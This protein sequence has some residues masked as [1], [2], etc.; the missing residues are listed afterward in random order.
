[1]KKLAIILLLSLAFSLPVRT[2]A[3]SA[4]WVSLQSDA[5]SLNAPG[6]KVNLSLNAMLN[7]AINGASLILHYD[8]VCFKIAGHKPGSL[9]PGTTSFIQEQPGQLD[10][11]YY[12]QGKGRGL[13][14]EGSLINIQLEALQ[15]CAS[16]VS[17]DSKTLT[18]GV[19][20]DK[21]LAF[22]LPG[23]E[24]RSMI[25]HLVPANGLAVFNPPSKAI[26]PSNSPELPLT[27]TALGSNLIWWIVAIVTI[28]ILVLII[29]VGLFLL[30]TDASSSRKKRPVSRNRI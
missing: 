12:F 24:Y 20:D 22:N 27:S 18:L 19:L 21:G 3:Q 7:S 11:T 16:D 29:I 23:V 9:L 4:N 8:P 25:V 1:M 14:G 5:T 2:R 13:T 28:L 10:L 30:L 26:L 17:V 6:Q 15:L